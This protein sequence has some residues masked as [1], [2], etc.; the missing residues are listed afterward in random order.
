M[1]RP[2]HLECTGR[3]GTRRA[4]SRTC[5]PAGLCC[6][7]RLSA[8]ARR[9]GGSPQL[10]NGLSKWV[11]P[12]PPQLYPRCTHPITVVKGSDGG[13][14]ATAH[15]RDQARERRDFGVADGTRQAATR[16]RARASAVS[17]D[18][19]CMLSV[20]RERGFVYCKKTPRAPTKPNTRK[21]LGS[22]TR[23]R[24]IYT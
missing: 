15:T 24:Y 8:G 14:A 9:A 13:T 5:A 16:A 18:L 19:I 17:H 2:G 10:I 22:S 20:I 23:L 3:S 21:P 12:Q 7:V 11:S 6:S 4:A 1:P